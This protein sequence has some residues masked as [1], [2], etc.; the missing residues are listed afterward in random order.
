MLRARDSKPTDVTA[1]ARI[2]LD[3]WSASLGRLVDS[4]VRE[5]FNSRNPFLAFLRK[6]D[7]GLLVACNDGDL[8]GFAA[9][10]TGP[11]ELSDLWIAPAFWGHGAGRA[12]LEAVTNNA[13]EAGQSHLNLEVMVGN[14]RAVAFYKAA[15]FETDWQR[16]VPDK[17]LG[18]TIAK[19]GMSKPLTP[20]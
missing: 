8:I 1:L 9:S 13:I 18:V 11:G 17:S 19:L 2:G 15:G 14:A 6:P 4:G 3:A 5:R 7:I 10:E 16:E 20:L 12:L